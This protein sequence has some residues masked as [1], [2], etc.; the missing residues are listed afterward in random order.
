MSHPYKI[1]ADYSIRT[2]TTIDTGRV[3]DVTEHEIVLEDAAVLVIGEVKP[4]P[5]GRVIIGRHSVINAM[6][7]EIETLRKV[8]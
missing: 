4:F 5:A 1:G 7:I 3:V 6:P 2:A 8:D